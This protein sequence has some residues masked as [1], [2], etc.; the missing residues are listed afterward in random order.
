VS[1]QPPANTT[2]ASFSAAAKPEVVTIAKNTP[3]KANQKSI[4][5]YPEK[6]YAIAVVTVKLKLDNGDH[7][8]KSVRGL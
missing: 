6:K 4:V 5:F 2:A 3:D 1:E 7:T 8:T